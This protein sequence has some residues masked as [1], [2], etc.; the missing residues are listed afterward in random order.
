MQS[1]RTTK[2]VQDKIDQDTIDKYKLDE[3]AHT[4]TLG[5]TELG[6]GSYGTVCLG[7]I[8][9]IDVA[10]KTVQVDVRATT[11]DIKNEITI[12]AE[13]TDS[14]APFTVKL[15]YHN[16]SSTNIS[17]VIGM[18]YAA[19]GSLD[20][21]FPQ[22]KDNEIFN[23]VFGLAKALDHM[24]TYNILHCDLK[25]EN[26]LLDASLNPLLCDFGLSKRIGID[27][28]DNPN[29]FGTP[30]FR[31]VELFKNNGQ[32]YN[33]FTKEYEYDFTEQNTK[34]SDIYT[35]HMTFCQILHQSAMLTLATTYFNHLN[36]I[37]DLIDYVNDGNR[38]PLPKC[39]QK[40]A[41]LITWG[42]TENPSNR[43][44]SGKVVEKLEEMQAE[45][46]ANNL[47]Q[48]NIN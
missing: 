1:S 2:H 43:P 18:S 31:A 5:T 42:W 37:D 19:H 32:F 23:V 10:F 8:D 24:H 30:L 45:N 33:C 12:H 35:L 15:M 4:I 3:T 41:A 22:L 20:K 16:Y 13:L 34:A 9:G 46:L 6:K 17:C 40:M 28:F 36:D 7:K 21:Y 48:L 14:S 44:T 25:A 26:V 29:R 27:S 38:I 47:K 39:S 11:E